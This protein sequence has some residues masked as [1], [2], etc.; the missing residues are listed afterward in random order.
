VLIDL[1]DRL[2]CPVCGA[3]L[4]SADRVLRCPTGHCFDIA[5]QG[6]VNLLPGDAR[7]GT[8]DTPE[9]VRS[10]VAFLGAGH[11][12]SLASLL[13]GEVVDGLPE[14]SCVLDA[15]AGTGYYLGAVLE[16]APGSVGL[17]LDISK[18]AL[19]RA[20][21]EHPRIGAAVWDLWRPLPVPTGSI[22]V[23]MNVFAP[24][25]GSEF[26]RVLRPDGAL[27]VVTPTSRHLGELVGP[28]G[29]L[30]VD[31]RKSERM[32]ETLGER[33]L[34]ERYDEHEF[35]LRL[36][37]S[38]VETLVGMGPSAGHIPGEELSER[39]TALPDPM[40]IT[41]S[42]RISRFGPV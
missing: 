23:I 36:S 11:F 37:H 32:A 9:M 16:R 31:E 42:F 12:S 20:V 13:A 2:R 27:F 35:T 21:R 1:V 14:G 5:K 29:L 8:A 38:E 39:L 7:A 33:F 41:A 30:S 26:H 18:F 3:G 6:Y 34:Q 17:A 22:N 19:R 24:R 4:A 40:Q 15:G 25:N 10:R 28:L